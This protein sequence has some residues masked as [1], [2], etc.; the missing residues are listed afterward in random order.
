MYLQQVNQFPVDRVKVCKKDVCV[1]ARG[2]NAKAIVGALAFM[3]V[4][5]GIAALASK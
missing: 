2:D 4:C 1:E 5:F 3:F